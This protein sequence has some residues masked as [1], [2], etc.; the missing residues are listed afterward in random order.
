[1]R[2][3][4]AF[5][6]KE[7]TEQLRS[8]RLY[9]LGA[10]FLFFG[11]MSPATAKLMPKII[12]LVAEQDQSFKIEAVKEVSAL[13]SFDQFFKN[14]STSLIVFVIMQAG[15]FTREYSSGT[16]LLSLTRGMERSKVIAAKALTLTAVWTACYLVCF[17]TT[18]AYTAYFWDMSVVNDLWTAVLL[19]WIY[20]LWYIAMIVFFSTFLNSATA[21]I[22]CTGAIFLAGDLLAMIPKAE[23]FIPTYLSGSSGLL[24]AR[25]FD[26][27]PALVITLVSIV[28]LLAASVPVFNKKQ[29]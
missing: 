9:I 24:R 7:F 1:M 21:V 3:L 8:R 15:I 28:L 19:W 12:E 10:V 5:I 11:I 20:G 22:A 13:D 25:D 4:N 26:Y 23:R 29:L 27:T 6:K 2:Q 16:L 18:Y 17:G 14:V